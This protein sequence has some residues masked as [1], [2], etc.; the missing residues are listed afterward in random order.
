MFRFTKTYTNNLTYATI[1][2][3]RNLL[4][5][6]LLFT[7]C[8]AAHCRFH[9]SSVLTSAVLPFLLRVPATQPRSTSLLNVGSC[10]NVG[11][12]GRHYD[13]RNFS[14]CHGPSVQHVNDPKYEVNGFVPIKKGLLKRQKKI[15]CHFKLS[16]RERSFRTDIDLG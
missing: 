11:Y 3:L 4:I 16:F 9:R 2:V 7:S 5:T 6:H 8:S 13:A 10:S 1:K 12:P 14:P 15:L